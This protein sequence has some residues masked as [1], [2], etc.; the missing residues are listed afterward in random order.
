MGDSDQ[1]AFLAP[2]AEQAVVL[3]R[4]VGLFGVRGGPGALDESRA[5]GLIA[6]A[7]AAGIALPPLSSLPG[8]R[9]AQAAA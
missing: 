3:G 2:P 8:A 5:Q 9:P 4:Q 7:D 1:G 6:G